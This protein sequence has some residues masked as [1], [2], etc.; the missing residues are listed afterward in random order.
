MTNTS[1]LANR[2]DGAIEKTP[3]GELNWKISAERRAQN[4]EGEGA[5]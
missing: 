1:P 3:W 4:H 2:A 5:A